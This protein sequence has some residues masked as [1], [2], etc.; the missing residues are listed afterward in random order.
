ME[1][2][3][4]SN[5]VL[6]PSADVI[7]RHAC[8][9]SEKQPRCLFFSSRWDTFIVREELS[10]F[11]WWCYYERMFQNIY[12]GVKKSTKNSIFKKVLKK[13]Y[14]L[15]PLNMFLGKLKPILKDIS[16][17][18]AKVICCLKKILLSIRA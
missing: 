3:F 11:L 2:T 7:P 18:K 9:Y 13:I 8:Q 12:P 14:M 5:I 10:S 6:V 17:K 1:P 15:S 4:L 16:Q